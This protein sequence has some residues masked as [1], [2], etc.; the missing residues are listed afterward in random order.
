MVEKG[1]FLGTMVASPIT[2]PGVDSSEQSEPTRPRRLIG[3]QHPGHQRPNS[4]SGRLRPADSKRQRATH[5]SRRVSCWPHEPLPSPVHCSLRRTDF[6]S[7]RHSGLPV[8]P[9]S[10]QHWARASVLRVPGRAAP[11]RRERARPGPW[12]GRPGP[13]GR[14]GD[15]RW[16]RRRR[17]WRPPAWRTCGRGVGRG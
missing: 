9:R 6:Q 1:S 8:E 3:F 10:T 13:P 17:R 12:P 4:S 7:V 2:R 14:R 15:G 16:R 11:V 5:R